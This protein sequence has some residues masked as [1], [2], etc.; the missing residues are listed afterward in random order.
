MSVDIFTIKTVPALIAYLLLRERSKF[1]QASKV[2]QLY[3]HQTSFLLFVEQPISYTFHVVSATTLSDSLAIP[4]GNGVVKAAT[5]ELRITTLVDGVV[6]TSNI[7]K[8]NDVIICGPKLEYYVLTN[9]KALNNYDFSY[10]N[11]EDNNKSHTVI[12]MATKSS[13]KPFIQVR[14][15]DFEKCPHLI[16]RS[17]SPSWGGSMIVDPDDFIGFEEGV[18]P[19]VYRLVSRK[20]DP[21]DEQSVFAHLS[22][23]LEGNIYRIEKNIFPTTYEISYR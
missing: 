2:P 1:A 6:E 3:Q 8:L 16:S 4:S 13:L 10:D 19:E 11:T 15:D 21:T 17:F 22:K 12:S 5:T 7:A 23:S 9:D 14:S 18:V 20:G